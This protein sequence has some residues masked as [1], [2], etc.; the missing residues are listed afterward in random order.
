LHAEYYSNYKILLLTSSLS[1]FS[2]Q[3]IIPTIFPH[4]YKKVA[5]SGKSTDTCHISWKF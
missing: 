1:Y 2:D 5:P 3:P 4:V